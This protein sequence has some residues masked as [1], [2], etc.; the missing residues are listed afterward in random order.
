[1]VR[2][3]SDQKPSFDKWLSEA[4][5]ALL[6]RHRPPGNLDKL[7][8]TLTERL[9][10][11]LRQH[12]KKIVRHEIIAKF[13]EILKEYI[14][15]FAKILQDA[16]SARMKAETVHGLMKR[17]AHK[18][19]PDFPQWVIEE[20]LAEMRGRV[21]APHTE[22]ESALS[23]IN[24]LRFTDA[25]ERKFA[26][27]TFRTPY[28]ALKDVASDKL[29][30]A[31]IAGMQFGLPYDADIYR[32]INR[33]GFSAARKLGCDALIIGGGLLHMELKKRSGPGRLVNDVLS[34]RDIDFESFADDYQEEARM[35]DESGSCDPIFI[36]VEEE[37]LNVLL[38]GLFKVTRRPSRTGS[39]TV[40]EFDKP[41]YVLLNANDL[42]VPRAAAHFHL[43][44]KQMQRWREADA[45]AKE[46]AREV[47]VYE[48]FLASG[49][50]TQAR[51][52]RTANDL[53]EARIASARAHA[54]ASRFR[55]S[56]LHKVQNKKVLRRAIGYFVEKIEEAIPN[57]TVIGT[58]GAYMRFGANQ[59]I[60]HFISATKP[61]HIKRL[62]SYGP[63]QR[64]DELA[65]LTLSMHPGAIYFRKGSRENYKHEG[66]YLG[67]ASFCEAPI[68]VDPSP[69]LEALEGFETRMPVVNAVKDEMF[70]G[71]MT[72][73]SLDNRF[74]PHAEALSLEAVRYN[75][76]PKD[77]KTGRTAPRYVYEALW[78]DWHISAANRNWLRTREG[79]P[80]G[81][82]E[83]GCELMMQSGMDRSGRA[84][85]FGMTVADDLTQGNHFGTH[86]RPHHNART[87]AEL[88][89]EVQDELR[90][91][92]SSNARDR[93][94][95]KD[96]LLR[97]LTDQ[98]GMFR[99]AHHWGT[100][101]KELNVV[102]DRYER[103][104]KGMLLRARDSGVVMHGISTYNRSHTDARD[105]GLINFGSG[106]HATKT[107]QGAV[108]EGELVADRL[109]VA[110][111][112]DPDLK[113]LDLRK[114]IC[115]PMFQD[116]SIGFGILQVGER[117]PVWGVHVAGTPPKRDSWYDLTHGWTQVNR[118]R[119][120]VSTLFRRG[121]PIVMKTGDKHFY[122]EDKSG[123][124]TTV[125]G[126]S[127]TH[128]DA[129]ADIAGG[130]PENNGGLVFIG[131]PVDGQDRAPV[132][133]KHLTP[134]TMQ[135]FLTSGEPFPWQ[136]FLPNAA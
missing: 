100:Q 44:Y 85:V 104:F 131:Y 92:A 64:R 53:A 14:R 134:K 75:G 13:Q 36:T 10:H 94:E 93:E 78:T 60:V 90:R 59:H 18:G 34:G 76:Q 107:V 125:M 67:T 80:I 42:E 106:N 69:I 84:Y 105:I 3:Q 19:A 41:V 116:Q 47:A 81:I 124:N 86:L 15:D 21:K 26:A 72:T 133:S 73:I 8:A 130:L 38:R 12:K 97:E 108:F 132:I 56:N 49:K 120:D 39:G 1:M 45:I 29:K 37:F 115:G 136:D 89:Y 127:S 111:R 98:V 79:V 50:G 31:V 2:K 58:G 48:R 22:L 126:S 91:I 5:R 129:F 6:A 63:D 88:L 57:C 30:I 20:L 51:R 74:M 103:L 65:D 96:R 4:V 112:N 110:L 17:H 113:G 123:N 117:G 87:N 32:N 68:L 102:L 46:K 61:A 118:Q 28:H 16:A 62:K 114:L 121:I 70:N 119:G 83:A 35:I 54:K 24:R 23:G 25:Q 55:M 99:P 95:A 33:C 122:G 101:L 9:P 52:G 40:D 135:D 71:G 82:L 109:R 27:S 66:K 11:E 128:T 7:A 77:P 43:L